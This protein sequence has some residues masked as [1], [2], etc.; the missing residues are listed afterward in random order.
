VRWFE[1]LAGKGGDRGR[2]W[3]AKK[4]GEGL[5]ITCCLFRMGRKLE[6]VKCASE[7]QTLAHDT[8]VA[9]TGAS[10]RLIL[11]LAGGS[12]RL[13]G[14]CL[15]IVALVAQSG[16]CWLMEREGYHCPAEVWLRLPWKGEGAGRLLR[17]VVHEPARWIPAQ[18]GQGSAQGGDDNRHPCGVSVKMDI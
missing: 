13:N 15:E 14:Q 8:P 9:G 10:R 12:R 17:E 18:V 2:G 3:G 7:T 6:G 1:Y 5:K 11:G 16:G 4:E